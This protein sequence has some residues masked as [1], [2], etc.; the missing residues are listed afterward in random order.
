MRNKQQEMVLADMYIE[1]G[2]VWE[3]CPR[4]ALRRVS[5]VLKDE[6]D[7][8]VNAGFENEFYLLKSILRYVSQVFP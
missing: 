6:F 4:E 5:K 3:Y 8:V 1:P 2:K 7:L